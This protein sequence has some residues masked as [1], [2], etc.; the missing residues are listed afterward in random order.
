M[1]VFT[2]SDFLYVIDQQ[3]IHNRNK[4]LFYEIANGRLILSPSKETVE[5]LVR[6][7][8]EVSAFIQ[9]A[10][11]ED[12]YQHLL[13]YAADKTLNLFTEVNQYLNFNDTHKRKLEKIYQDFFERI[14]TIATHGEITKEI[15]QLFDLHYRNLQSFLLESNGSE[16]FKKY[17]ESPNIIY[18]ECAEYSPSF[19]LG[20]FGIDLLTIEEPVLDLGCG[21]HASLVQFL[22]KK[23]I[24]AYG[25]DRSVSSNRYTYRMNWLESTFCPKTWGTVISHMAFSNHFTHHHIKADGDYER[26]ARKYMEILY[27]LKIGGS[28]YYAPG[29]P[30]IEKVLSSNHESFVIQVNEHATKVIRVSE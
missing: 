19:Q 2:F 13:S 24:E 15:D 28:F 27:S 3:L 30:F 17:K 6:R 22:R 11:K 14:C 25:M 21:V 12:T 8:D 20:L 4:S 7:I 16:I 23:G 18:V 1:R 5:L 29:L 9:L 26:Y 10:A